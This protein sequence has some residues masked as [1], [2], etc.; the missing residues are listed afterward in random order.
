[1][2]VRGRIALHFMNWNGFRPDS[3]GPFFFAVTPFGG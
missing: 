3:L 1:V 2:N